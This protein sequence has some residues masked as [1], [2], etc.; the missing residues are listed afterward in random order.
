MG[1][2]GILTNVSKRKKIMNKL[3][4]KVEKMVSAKRLAFFFRRGEKFSSIIL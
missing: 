1:S 4:G 3:F 2:I